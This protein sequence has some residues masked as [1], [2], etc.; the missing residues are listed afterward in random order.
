MLPFCSENLQELVKKWNL[1]F[2]LDRWYRKKYE[3]SFGSP[4]HR[5]LSFINM[6]FEYYEFYIYEY[7][8]KLQKERL[9]DKINDDFLEIYDGEYIKGK[10]N[11]IKRRE[12]DKKNIDQ[13]F[14]ELDIDNMK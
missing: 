14:E 3:I 8:P 13:M 6:Y 10:G 5:E 11:F 4:K 12:L 1:L 7:K 9:K 2:P